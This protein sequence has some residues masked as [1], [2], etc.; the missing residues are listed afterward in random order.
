MIVVTMTLVNI[1]WGRL[2]SRKVSGRNVSMMSLDI[3]FDYCA[4][5]LA[6]PPRIDWSNEFLMG[7]LLMRLVVIPV[8]FRDIN[9][10]PG[11]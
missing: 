10:W 11:S 9:L 3:N 2:A 4:I 8:V 7:H 5:V 6:S 1:D